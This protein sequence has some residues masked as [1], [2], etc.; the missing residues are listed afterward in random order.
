MNLTEGAEKFHPPPLVNEREEDS[1]KFITVTRLHS[2]MEMIVA[3]I[4]SKSV[5]FTCLLYLFAALLE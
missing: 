4:T 5:L 1:L 3:V 2:V